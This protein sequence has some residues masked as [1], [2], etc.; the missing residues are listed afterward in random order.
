VI[1]TASSWRDRRCLALLER[2][3]GELAAG[4]AAAGSAGDA[5]LSSDPRWTV[6]AA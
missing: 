4:L 2:R 3:V 5:A 6:E 1:D